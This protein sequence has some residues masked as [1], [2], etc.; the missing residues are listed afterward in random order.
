MLRHSPIFLKKYQKLPL[1]LQLKVDERIQLFLA[2]RHH[3][4]LK[5]HRLK[6]SLQ[7]TLSINVTGD[8]RVWLVEQQENDQHV[9]TFINVGSHSQLY[10]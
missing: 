7:H 10:G 4:L 6:G 5:L 8:Y 2:D 9:I 3:P 1:D